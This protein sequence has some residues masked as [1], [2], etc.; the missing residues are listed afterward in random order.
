M[1]NTL[2]TNIA[3]LDKQIEDLFPTVFESQRMLA[4]QGLSDSD[5]RDA[6]ALL[7]LDLRRCRT[8]LRQARRAL[9]RVNPTS[10]SAT[11]AA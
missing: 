2:L 1:N 3:S 10:T 6:M 5:A 4:N 7:E 9:A 11:P 8:H